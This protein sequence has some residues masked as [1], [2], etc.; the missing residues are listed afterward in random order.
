MTQ[1]ERE[2][3]QLENDLME[4]RISNKEFNEQMSEL[5]REYRLAAQEAAQDAYDREMSNW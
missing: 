2:E 4:G 5:Q 1:F 3:Q